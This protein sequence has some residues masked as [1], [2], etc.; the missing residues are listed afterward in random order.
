MK[1]SDMYKLDLEQTTDL[2]K[3]IGDKRTV[4]VEGDIGTGKSSILK[5]LAEQLPDY[6]PCYFDA[7]TKDTGDISIPKF[8]DLDGNDF[9]SYAPNEEFGIQ[10]GKRVILM[11]DEYG[12]ANRGVKTALTRTLLERYVGNTKLPEGSIVFATTNLASEGVGD[13]LKAHEGNR[14]ITVKTRKPSVRQ[15]LSWG[16]KNEVHHSVLGW[17]RD[18]PN[19][20]QS[21]TELGKDEENP[22]IYNPR[23][24]ERSFVTPRSLETAS[25]IIKCRG[26]MDD[27][28]LTAALMGAIGERG[29]LDL[30]AFVTLA[31]Q[32]PSLDSIKSDPETAVV[33]TSA[34]AV[35]MVVY[36]TLA[37]IDRSWVKD[38]MVYFNRL[39]AEAQGLFANG[40][41][42]TKYPQA[43]QEIVFGCDLFTQWS[44]ANQH[45][46]TQ[47]KK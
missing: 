14:V 10:F 22:Y 3:A 43:K 20:L 23:K 19:L 4:L 11:I 8:K 16:I 41:R 34:G 30:M 28:T 7:T 26:A 39:D 42:D 5:A 1:T 24:P 6:V 32:L 33:P 36:R 2:I 45:M 40:V 9:V 21:F 44:L 13:L 18:N 17:V 29:A 35:C 27:V 31:D 12:K 37:N 38:W 15:W 47:D 46:F 25:D